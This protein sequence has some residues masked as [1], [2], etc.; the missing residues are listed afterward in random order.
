MIEWRGNYFN[1]SP[2]RHS[3]FNCGGHYLNTVI[4]TMRHG[5]VIDNKNER[6]AFFITFFFGVVVFLVL[7]K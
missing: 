2:Y 1:V 7:E 3:Q 6:N 4:K 5:I